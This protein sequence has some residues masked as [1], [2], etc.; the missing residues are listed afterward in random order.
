MGLI[1]KKILKKKAK[2][3]EK[4]INELKVE[5]VYLILWKIRELTSVVRGLL[6]APSNSN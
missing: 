4:S 5:F 2:A 3:M 1:G 6:T